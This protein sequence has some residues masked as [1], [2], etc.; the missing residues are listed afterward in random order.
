MKGVCVS[1]QRAD[2]V[3]TMGMES[4][5]CVTLINYPRFPTEQTTSESHAFDLAEHLC[6]KM[7]QGS[8]C[9]ECPQ[10]TFWFSRREQDQPAEQTGFDL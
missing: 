8:Y 7:F 5:V 1:V 6:K 4:G 3:Y 10:E 2:Y 9:V